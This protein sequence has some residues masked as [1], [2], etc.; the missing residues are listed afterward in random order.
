LAPSLL[1]ARF[2][3]VLRFPLTELFGEGSGWLSIAVDIVRVTLG[4]A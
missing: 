4:E 2:R 3:N 1:K